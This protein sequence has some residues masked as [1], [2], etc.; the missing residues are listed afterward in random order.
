MPKQRNMRQ[1]TGALVVPMFCAVLT[2]YFGYNAIFGGR[3]LLAWGQTERQLIDARLK[4]AKLHSANQALG[5]RIALMQDSAIDPD[6]LEEIAR[7][8]LRETAPGEVAIPR[9]KR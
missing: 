9:E 5:H 6:L 3:G 7:E 2:A 1:G 4:Y 8:R